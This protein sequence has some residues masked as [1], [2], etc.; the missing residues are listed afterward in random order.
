MK[1]LQ[2]SKYIRI[3]RKLQTEGEASNIDLNRICLN[4]RS[5]ISEMRKDGHRI[6]SM[7]IN[8][9]VWRYVYLGQETGE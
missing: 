2:K 1:T 8:E 6:V 4:Y 7:R 3:L 5:R 9:S